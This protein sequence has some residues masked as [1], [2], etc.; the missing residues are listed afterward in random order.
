MHPKHETIGNPT[1]A[2]KIKRHRRV[3]G[4]V[5]ILVGIAALFVAGLLIS[6]LRTQRQASPR[7]SAQQMA[8]TY[9]GVQEFI[10]ANE[11]GV[12]FNDVYPPD[13]PADK[14]GLVG[15]DIITTF[16]GRAV[17]HKGDMSDVLR[18]T[19][20]GK[21]VEVT[22]LRDRETKKTQLTTISEEQF[23]RL[24]DSFENR[25]GGHGSFGFEDTE[26]VPIAGSNISGVR[27]NDLSSSGPAAL[28]GIQEGDIVI[29]FDGAPIRKR[30]ELITRVRRAIPYNTVR[31][32]VM[33]GPQRL[34]IPVK[35][36]K[37]G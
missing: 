6:M 34:E 15:G 25:P 31:V 20:V 10:N 8:E 22:Y 32:V 13:S 12:T 27:L 19:P 7:A 18:Q 33:R 28:A 17:N 9:F 21:T 35:M 16:D 5:W 36:G 11:G 4:M 29:E 23:E 24:V 1:S 30:G 3:S 14:A 2:P 26:T 37:R